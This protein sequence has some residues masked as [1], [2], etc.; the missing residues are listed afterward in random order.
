MGAVSLGTMIFY[1]VGVFAGGILL[2]LDTLVSQ[3]FGAGDH[4][5]CRHSLINGIRLA[6]FLVPVV[7]ALVWASIPLLGRFG[8]DPAVLQEVRP[9]L[10]ALNWSTLPLLLF[11]A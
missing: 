1:G 4:D 3:A 11:F 9:Y 7:M 6:L 10:G 5:D 2:G 8:I